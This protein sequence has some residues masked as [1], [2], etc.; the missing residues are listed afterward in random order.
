[1]TVYGPNHIFDFAVIGGG[2]FGA[3]AARHLAEAGHDVVLLAPAEPE[4]TST[5]RGPFGSHYDEARITRLLDADPFWSQLA[6]AA[7]ERY[8]A[9]E[10]ASGVTFH[11][12]K[13]YLGI[14]VEGFRET[15]YDEPGRFESST[16]GDDFVAASMQVGAAADASADRLTGAGIAERFPFLSPGTDES[17]FLEGPPAG[18]VNPRALARAQRVLVEAAGATVLPRTAVT[19]TDTIDAVDV[20]TDDATRV[21]ARRALL[22]AGAYSNDLLIRPLDLEVQGRTLVFARLDAAL[23]DALSS[24]PSIIHVPS[25]APTTYLLPP[26]TYPDGET[27]VKIGVDAWDH[28]LRTPSEVSEWF[29]ATAGDDEERATADAQLS[30]LIPSLASAPKHTSTCVYTMTASG[31]PYVGMVSE[32]LAVAVGGNGKGAKSSDEIGRLGASVLLGESVDERLTPR[33][34]QH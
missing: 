25:E 32:R 16:G 17:G 24:M 33:F 21:L 14:G 5:H 6:Q 22:A 11:H 1:M 4:E 15:K 19:V 34:T 31:Y 20:V 8:P 7:I 29:R 26:V 3:A 2:L 13:A 28:P 10:S 9:I 30:A 27:Y 18:H 12:P 23:K